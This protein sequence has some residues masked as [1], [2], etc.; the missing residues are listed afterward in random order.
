MPIQNLRKI[1]NMIMVAKEITG[2]YEKIPV[3]MPLICNQLGCMESHYNLAS[4]PIQNMLM[5]DNLVMVAKEITGYYEKILVVMA[6]S[7]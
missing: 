5:I 1:N 6:T 2:C 3:A 7:M 4:M